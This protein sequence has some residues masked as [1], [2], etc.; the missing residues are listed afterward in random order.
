MATYEQLCAKYEHGI[1]CPADFS[2]PSHVIDLWA[3]DPRDLLA[4]HWV[5]S[6]HSSERKISYR[7]LSALS[8]RAA[9]ALEKRGIKKGDRV[10]VQLPRICEW[11][12][13]GDSSRR[14]NLV[15]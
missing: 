6:D 1:P 3:R 2:F 13:F 9:I 12:E 7:E 14:V 4:I 8:N 15:P 11:C 10:M 5:A